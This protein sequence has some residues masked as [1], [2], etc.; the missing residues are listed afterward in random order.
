[1]KSVVKIVKRGAQELKDLETGRD[2]KTGRQGQREIVNTVKSWVV[3]LEQ[4]RRAQERTYS[5]LTK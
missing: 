1:M 5:L 4:R 2:A 3:A